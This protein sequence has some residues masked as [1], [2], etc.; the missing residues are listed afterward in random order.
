MSSVEPLQETKVPLPPEL[1]HMILEEELEELDGTYDS[2]EL[3]SI[4]T[5]QTSKTLEPAESVAPP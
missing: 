5:E 2:E 4:N 1:D 3:E